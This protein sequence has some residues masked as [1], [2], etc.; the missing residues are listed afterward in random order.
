MRNQLVPW[1][2][3]KAALSPEILPEFGEHKAYCEPF[4]GGM[5]MLLRKEKCSRE[6]VNDLHQDLTNLARVVAHPT[7]GAALYRRI[8]RLLCCEQL[9]RE[10]RERLKRPFEASLERAVDYFYVSWM[11]RSGNIGASTCNSMAHGYKASSSV[12]A[13]KLRSAVESI[14]AWRSRLRDVTITN[15][16][17][18]AL[19]DQLADE[20]GMLIYCDPPYIAKSGT[21]H[22]DL[23][24]EDHVRLA[25]ALKR[26]TKARVIVS[27]TDHPTLADLYPKNRWVKRQLLHKCQTGKLAKKGLWKPPEVL[28]INGPSLAV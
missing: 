17:A 28:L 10:A 20:P 26:F 23:Q 6:T 12:C 9:H 27:Y 21:Y 5:A 1:F 14:N 15:R 8:S 3:S 4:A 16:D 22:F 2:G 11:G 7:E 19:L 25:E 13:R 18:F 24:P